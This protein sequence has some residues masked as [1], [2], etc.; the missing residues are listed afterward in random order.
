MSAWISPCDTVRSIPFRISLPSTVAWRPR[1]SSV[2]VSCRV[3]VSVTVHLDLDL[4][5]LHLHRIRAH[6]HRR[7]Q[8]PGPPRLQI[9]RRPVL[10]ALYGPEVAVY[11]A[12]GQVP[13][14]RRG[15][16][17]QRCEPALAR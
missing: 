14:C 6:P 8:G 12:P 4:V 9:E 15:A 13:V 7:R 10:R 11:L 16:V 5:V 3:A 17:V 1:I 2:A